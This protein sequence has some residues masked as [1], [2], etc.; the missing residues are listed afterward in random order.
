M[1]RDFGQGL[2]MQK[3]S[4]LYIN[5]TTLRAQGS[6]LPP[7]TFHISSHFQGL[8]PPNPKLQAGSPTIHTASL[9]MSPFG[10][11]KGRGVERKP[12]Q[13]GM[14]FHYFVNI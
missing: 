14:K 9:E 10:T 5:L 7:D 12:E 6:S 8:A 3:A 2:W 13:M 4:L 1:P 11:G